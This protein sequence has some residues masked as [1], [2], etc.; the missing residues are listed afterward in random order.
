MIVL[1][2]DHISVLR[3]DSDPRHSKLKDR[4]RVAVSSEDIATTVITVEEQLRGWLARIHSE[5]HPAGQV[6]WYGKLTELLGFIQSWRIEPFDLSAA[7][8]LQR[9]RAQRVRLG[10]QDLKI[11]SIALTRDALLLTAN[12]RDFSRVP[13]LRAEDWLGA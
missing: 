1:D 8:Q 6:M 11:A 3:Y 9:L 2:T 12:L 4:L 10:T 5:K 13:G 7:E